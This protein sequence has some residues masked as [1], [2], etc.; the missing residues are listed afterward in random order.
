M[1]I[2]SGSQQSVDFFLMVIEC[3]PKLQSY[4]KHIINHKFEKL[5][6]FLILQFLLWLGLA[7]SIM[8]LTLTEQ[9][10]Q[11]GAATIFFAVVLLILELLTMCYDYKSYLTISIFNY[12]DSIML[13]GIIIVVSIDFFLD[14]NFVLMNIYVVLLLL[15]CMRSLME[16]RVFNLLR[17]FSGMLLQ[18]YYDI[19][20]FL[21][22]YTLFITTY[23]IVMS[24]TVNMYQVNDFSFSDLLLQGLNV[25]FNN[26]DLTDYYGFWSWVF[27]FFTIISISIMMLNVIIAVVGN[28]YQ[29]YENKKHEYD[30]LEKLDQIVNFD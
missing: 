18:A 4:F 7:I 21:C 5:Y 25:G 30:L 28:T 26:W 22:C 2:D 13:F 10:N 9:E 1:V 24:M 29:R 23:S 19:F 6:L 14:R 16:I 3:H 20:P 15:A 17:H 11:G 27:F 12:M 8:V